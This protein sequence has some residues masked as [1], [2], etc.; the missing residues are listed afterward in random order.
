MTYFIS[1]KFRRRMSLFP[2]CGN[3]VITC[4]P[5]TIEEEDIRKNEEYIEKECK[6]K[7]VIILSIQKLSD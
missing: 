7:D 5:T 2:D 3:A 4:K 6:I 1:F